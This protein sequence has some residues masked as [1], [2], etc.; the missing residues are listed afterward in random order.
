MVNKI[1]VLDASLQ[2]KKTIQTIFDFIKQPVLI[3][4]SN[5]LT[6]ELFT[7]VFALFLFSKNSTKEQLNLI[8]PFLFEEKSISLIFLGDIPSYCKPLMLGKKSNFI[9]STEDPLCHLDL[10]EVINNSRQYYQSGCNE[11]SN[12]ND[13]LVGISKEIKNVRELIEQVSSVD[14]NVLILGESGTGKEITAQSIHDCSPRASQPFV[15]INCGAIP[16]DLLESELFGHEKGAFTG[17]ISTRKGRFELANG[18]TLFLD[19]IGDMPLAMQVKLLRVLQERK[20]ERVGSNQSIEVDVRIIAATHRDLDKQIDKGE[21]REDLYYRLNVFPIDIPP[22]RNRTEDILLLIQELASRLDKNGRASV[23]LTHDAIHA[24]CQY[25]WPGNIRELANMVERL[26]ILYPN[27]VVDYNALPKRYKHQ[28]IV[29]SSEVVNLEHHDES[30]SVAS[31]IN[32]NSQGI[33]LKDHLVKTEVR[34]IMQAL[35]ENNWVVARAADYLS[36]RRTTLV[37]KIKKYG[38]TRSEKA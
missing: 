24:L 19:E 15:P 20:F 33:D 8:E 28:A 25:G 36:M 12:P 29:P 17:A 34:L 31:I 14:A 32:Q 37:E 13:E 6:R 7:D 30:I 18:G 1:M 10:E 3:A 22:L 2:Q 21:F 4:Q 5:E 9:Q 38:L 11:F 16:P 35:D 27:S 26:S 23:R